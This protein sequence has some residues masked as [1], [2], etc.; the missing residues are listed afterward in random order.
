MLFRCI[1]DG[2]DDCVL[3][4]GVSTSVLGIAKSYEENGAIVKKFPELRPFFRDLIDS[5]K[6][7]IWFTKKLS[8]EVKFVQ[9]NKINKNC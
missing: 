9:L 5:T 1:N 2:K 3:I 8:E 6:I 7:G 4:D